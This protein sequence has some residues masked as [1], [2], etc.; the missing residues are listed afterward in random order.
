MGSSAAASHPVLRRAR[1]LLGTLV[2]IGLTLDGDDDA[3]ALAGIDRA[4]SVIESIQRK[5]SRFDEASDIARFAAL[6]AGGRIEISDDSAQVLALAAELQRRSG[7]LF[8]ISLGSGPDQWRCDG[9]TLHK[10]A[11]GVCLDLGGIAKGHAVDRAVQAL[12]S[13]GA[14]A[15][16]VNAGGD[17]RVFGDIE[18]PLSLRDEA[19]GGSRP[20]AMLSLGAFATSHYGPG[21]R[22]ALAGSSLTRRHVS[23]AAPSCIWADALTKIAALTG[24]ESGVCRALMD[25]AGATAWWHDLP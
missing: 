16:W 6:P 18:L 17:L 22:C 10:L 11:E 15:G 9:A 25:D 8:D 23:V 5:L 7:G 20:F 19:S 24:P 2:E 21:S 4:F 3:P 14:K 13:G 1:P 12:Q